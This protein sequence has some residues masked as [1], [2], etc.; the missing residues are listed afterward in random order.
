MTPSLSGIFPALLT[1]L[2][3]AGTLNHDALAQL[4]GSIYAAQCQGVYVAGSTGEGL[5]LPLE[6]REEL[7]AAV[8]RLSPP[9][10]T[11]IVHTG[12]ASTAAAVRLTRHAADT[13]AKAVSSIGP[14]GSFSFEEVHGYYTQLAQATSLPLLL[15][16]FPAASPAVSTFAHIERLCEIPGVAG[17]KFTSFDL[18]TLSR[19]KGLGKLVFNG[20]DEVLAAGLLMG[21]DG[22]IGSFYN[23]EPGLFVALYAA[24]CSGDWTEARRLQGRINLLITIVLQ[25]PLFSALKRILSWRG[26][27]CGECVAPRRMLSEAEEERLRTSLTAAGFRVTP[28]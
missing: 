17:V 8:V 26:I 6:L 20:H 1:P 15:Y 25:F 22:G 24:A 19:A 28:E 13:G 5:L 12:A 16:F 3:S 4:L 11:V 18:Y 14:V 27:D 2:T 21:A 10:R 23:I 9:D 7:T